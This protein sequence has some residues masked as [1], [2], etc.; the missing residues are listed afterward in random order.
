MN[1]PLSQPSHFPI[2][3]CVLC[4]QTG[5]RLVVQNDL[6][7]VIAVDAESPDA[8]F[9]A[10]YRLIW[11]SHCVEITDLPASHQALIWQVILKIEACMRE[12]IQPH[13]MNLASFGNVVSHLHWHFIARFNWDSHFPQ[14]V[15]GQPQ[16]EVDPVQLSAIHA[17]HPQL[18]LRLQ[19]VLSDLN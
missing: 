2:S 1:T 7:R 14:S 18:D 9:P 4:E 19:Q 10:F 6:F 16:R 11:N 15:W 5:G 17:L 8:I 13:K 3:S 12:V